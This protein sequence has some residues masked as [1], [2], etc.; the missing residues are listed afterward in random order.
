MRDI[1]RLSE[2]DKKALFHNTAAKMGMTDAIIEKDFWVCYMLDYLFHRCAWKNNIA[3][4]GGTSLS[5]SYGLIERFSED[6]DLILDW[7]VLGYEKDEPWADRSNTKQDVFNKEAGT[8]TEAFLRNELMP[9]VIADLQDELSYDV[10]CYIED[11]DPQTVVFAYNR[12]FDDSAILPVIRL[13]IGA[14]AAWTPA[15]EKPI[16]SYAAEQYGR[17]FKQPS[18]EILTVLPK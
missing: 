8:K 14:L 9:A 18:T 4:K 6:I 13:E 11:D 3:F 16:T 12:S 5:K 15:E 17:L 10:N 1:A 7:R 2:K